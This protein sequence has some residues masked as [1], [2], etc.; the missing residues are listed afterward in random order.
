MSCL[1]WKNVFQLWLEGGKVLPFVVRR[2]SWSDYSSF[3]VKRVEISAKDWDNFAR[4]GKLYGKAYGD[5]VGRVR[6]CDI[7]LDCAGCYEWVRVEER[8]TKLSAT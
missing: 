4:T 6:G 1:V 5:F 8:E 2:W 7:Q 3:V